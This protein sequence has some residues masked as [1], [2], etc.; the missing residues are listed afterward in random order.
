MDAGFHKPP[1]T[2][3]SCWTAIDPQEEIPVRLIAARFAYVDQDI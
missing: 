3:R 2:G 1:G